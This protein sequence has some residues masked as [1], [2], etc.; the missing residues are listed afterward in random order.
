MW[1]YSIMASVQILAMVTLLLCAISAATTSAKSA[2]S[3]PGRGRW[4]ENPPRQPTEEE[5]ARIDCY[6]EDVWG[7]EDVTPESCSDR[8]CTYAESDV[9]EVPTCYVSADSTMGQGYR[10]TAERPGDGGGFE[11]ELEPRAGKRANLFS[12]HKHRQNPVDVLFSVQYYGPNVVRIKVGVYTR[13][14]WMTLVTIRG[15]AQRR[16]YGHVTLRQMQSHFAECITSVQI[17]R[18]FH[19][20]IL[21]YFYP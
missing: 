8:G 16:C 1:Q 3:D 14:T 12:R 2:S 11:L 6:P 18:I 21:F 4:R 13:S 19:G 15:A 7:N 10:V 17:M 20:N 9:D 5:K